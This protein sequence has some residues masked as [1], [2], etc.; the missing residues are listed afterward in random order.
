LIA[1]GNPAHG[2]VFGLTYNGNHIA[3]SG[4]VT[5]VA[6]F[7]GGV[8]GSF[9]DSLVYGG[10]TPAAFAVCTGSG[11]NVDFGTSNNSTVTTVTGCTHTTALATSSI[12]S[13][14]CQAVT[15][16]SVNSSASAPATTTGKLM[17][18]PAVSLQTVAG[19]QVSTSGG[20]SLDAYLT[21]GFVNFNVCNWTSRSITPGALTIN[22]E[23]HQ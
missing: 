12:A 22:W 18:N 13:S 19:Y 5:A 16:G 11:N 9:R 23:V 15:P 4:N 1:G 2:G 6:Q 14:T 7:T 17:W 3:N 20:L 8:T 10:T 21:N